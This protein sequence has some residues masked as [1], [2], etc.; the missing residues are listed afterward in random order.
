MFFE[1]GPEDAVTTAPLGFDK[2]GN[3]LYLLDSR[4]RDTGALFAHDLKTG[5]RRLIAADDRSDIGSVMSHPTEH[6]LEAASVTFDRREW[7]ILDE[8]VAAD[9]AYLE[10]VEDG[11]F[12]VT[13]RTLDDKTWSVSYVLDDGPVKFYLYDRPARQARYLFSS[14]DDLDEYPLVKMHSLVIKSRDGLNLVCYLSLP[15]GTD[16]D[17][18]GRPA[19]P[20]PLVLDVHGGPWARDMWGFNPYHQWLANRGYA[21]LNVN[22]RGSTGFGKNFVNAANG[23]WSAKMHDDLLDAVDWVV[24]NKVALP[25]KIAV[26]GG[27]YGGYATLVSLTFTPEVFCCGVDIVGP[28]SLITLL[29]NIPPYW[30]TSI[31]FMKQRVGDWTTEEGRAELLRRSPL[32]Y[33]DR[34]SRPLLIGQGA[35]DPRVTQLESDQIVAAMEA[36]GIPVT[37]VLFPDEGHGFARPENR[38]AFN[39]VTEA[40][41]AEHLGGRFQPVDDDF[42]GSSIRIPAGA[43]GVPGLPAALSEIGR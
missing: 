24:E 42:Q 33:V 26:M 2:S 37:Y 20:L 1:V 35:N 23:Q 38:M 13:S 29:E 17:Q 34:I 30:A 43:G 32:S 6:T 41:F 39:A 4:N 25:D 40:F 7:I 19:K 12:I 9:L 10:S 15:S 36:K 31:P 21:V 8:A 22:F 28:S 16:P 27:S 3:T 18:D 5:E 14:R 11:E